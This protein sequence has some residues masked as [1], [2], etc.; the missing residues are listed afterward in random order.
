MRHTRRRNR[1]PDPIA[2][3]EMVLRILE[4]LRKQLPSIVPSTDKA[5]I[6]ML[7]SARHV[8]RYPHTDTN[9]GRPTRWPRKDLLKVASTLKTIIEKEGSSISIKSFVDYYIPILKFPNDVV[10]ALANGD[11]NLF[12][13]TQLAR[14]TPDNL[15]TSWQETRRQRVSLLKAHVQSQSSGLKLRTK[16]K[17]LL[18]EI[19]I[20]APSRQGRSYGKIF[21]SGTDH[22]FY[23]QL[24]LIGKALSE[25]KPGDL[26]QEMI[27]DILTSG[28][29]WYLSIARAHKFIN[30]KKKSD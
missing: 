10:E 6:K 30:R 11:I 5:L 4:R 28:D 1:T 27:N 18:G 24:R 25:I 21:N 12:E 2:S 20:D 23:D 14:L 16:V 17:M 19:P 26:P 13:A 3:P 9:K 7:V 8:S 29:K 15:R 22:L